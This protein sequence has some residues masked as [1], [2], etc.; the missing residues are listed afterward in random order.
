MNNGVG[1]VHIIVEEPLNALYCPPTAQEEFCTVEL[2]DGPL[3]CPTVCATLTMM[4]HNAIRFGK[5]LI[6]MGEAASR[7][8]SDP[9]HSRLPAAEPE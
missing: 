4:P 6:Q 9:E 1:G 3:I 2:R 5:L 8:A 7:V